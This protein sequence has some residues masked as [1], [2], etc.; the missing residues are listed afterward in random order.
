MVSPPAP[1]APFI[2]ADRH[3][4]AFRHIHLVQTPNL[5]LA[6]GELGKFLFLRSKPRTPLQKKKATVSVQTNIGS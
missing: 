3:S 1:H 6:S 2:P 5:N 4:D